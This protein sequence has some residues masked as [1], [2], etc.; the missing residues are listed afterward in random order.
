MVRRLINQ[1]FVLIACIVT[2]HAFS[3]L[4]FY[5]IED[6]SRPVLDL[7]ISVSPAGRVVADINI[8]YFRV[9]CTE[10]L[11]QTLCEFFFPM[12]FGEFARSFVLQ[13]AMWPEIVI[14]PSPSLDL[15]PGFRHGTKPVFI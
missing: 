4:I 14:L 9:T 12:R 1:N 11:N 8:K 2:L 10:K 6:R 3:W 5:S 15:L 7:P 13:A